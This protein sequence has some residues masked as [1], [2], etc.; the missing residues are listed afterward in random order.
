MECFVEAM[1]GNPIRMID[2]TEMLNHIQESS[3]TTVASSDIGRVL[4]LM[5]AAQKGK[6]AL[7]A[8]VESQGED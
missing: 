4:Q 6:K 1:Q 2:L 5:R 7:V 3:T 8:E